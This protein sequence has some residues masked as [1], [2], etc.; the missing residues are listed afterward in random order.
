VPTLTNPEVRLPP[1]NVE[2]E[3]SVLGSV[4]I[5]HEVLD[6]L[7][8]FLHADDS[9]SS[10]MGW[11]WDA[12]LKLHERREPIDFGRCATRWKRAAS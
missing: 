7:L 11:I 3:E 1:H 2:A 8:P 6:R 10:K 9:L 4:P 5:D 12:F